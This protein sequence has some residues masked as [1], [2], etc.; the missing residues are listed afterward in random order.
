MAIDHNLFVVPS[1]VK[2]NSAELNKY[3]AEIFFVQKMDEIISEELNTLVQVL[4]MFN[5]TGL[6]LVLK[7]DKK[8]N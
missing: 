5:L 3:L 4:S 7:D 6:N 8:G 1:V 2:R